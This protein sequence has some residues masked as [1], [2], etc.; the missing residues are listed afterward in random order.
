M[1]Q[2]EVNFFIKLS[3]CDFQL[4]CSPDAWLRIWYFQWQ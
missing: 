3:L 1:K 4:D 2:I